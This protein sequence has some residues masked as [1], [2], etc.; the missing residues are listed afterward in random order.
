MVKKFPDTLQ[1]RMLFQ[2]VEPPSQFCPRSQWYGFEK[3]HNHFLSLLILAIG[4]VAFD[5]VVHCIRYTKTPLHTKKAQRGG[6]SVY[7]V[8]S[9]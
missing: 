1:R 3:V 6:G 2:P 4:G 7:I 9:E 8:W 5:L